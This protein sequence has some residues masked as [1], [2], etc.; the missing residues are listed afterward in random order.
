MN[1]PAVLTYEVWREKF[2]PNTLFPLETTGTELKLVNDI[3]QARPR[4]VWTVVDTPY[5][6]SIRPGVHFSNRRGFYITEH[7]Y[8]SIHIEVEL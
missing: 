5:G 7:P 3:A 1:I 2:A 4:H 8:P 6:T